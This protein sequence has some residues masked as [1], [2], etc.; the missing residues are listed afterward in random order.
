VRAIA[1]LRWFGSLLADVVPMNS[2]LQ[3]RAN[4][5][6]DALGRAIG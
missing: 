3:R 1:M 4:A 5:G 2:G 6:I